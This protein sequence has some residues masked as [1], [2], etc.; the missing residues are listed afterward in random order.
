MNKDLDPPDMCTG[1]R[2]LRVSDKTGILIFDPFKPP[3]WSLSLSPQT[4]TLDSLS[5]L[6]HGMLAFVKVFA[7]SCKN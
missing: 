2:E 6:E 3:N 7:S 5:E 4:K 1:R